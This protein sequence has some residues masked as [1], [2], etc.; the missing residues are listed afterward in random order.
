MSP[1]PID[2]LANAREIICDLENDV[3]EAREI[4]AVIEELLNRPIAF[5][6]D[7]PVLHGIHRLIAQAEIA[8][9]KIEQAWH[10][11]FEITKGGDA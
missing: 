1:G 11:L 3:S 10:A 7:D 2:A 9:A 4:L 5:E 8:S 6:K